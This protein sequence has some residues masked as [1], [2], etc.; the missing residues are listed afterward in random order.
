M[1]KETM[2]IHEETDKLIIYKCN[3]TR[4]RLHNVYY[5]YYLRK[6]SKRKHI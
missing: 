6:W 5:V 2:D 4:Q 1:G 3:I